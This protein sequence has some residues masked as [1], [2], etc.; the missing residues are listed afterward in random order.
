ML[1]VEFLDPFVL[2]VCVVSAIG[3]VHAVLDDRQREILAQLIERGPFGG[4]F[5]GGPFRREWA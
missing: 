5:G 4:R 3:K 1:A 2:G